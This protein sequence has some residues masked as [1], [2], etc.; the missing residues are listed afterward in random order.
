L[1]QNLSRTRLFL[2]AVAAVSVALIGF[3]AAAQASPPP[4]SLNVFCPPFPLEHEDAQLSAG[5]AGDNLETRLVSFGRR[6]IIAGELRDAEG[7]GIPGEPLCIEERPRFPLAPYTMIG[8]TTTRADGTWS[9]TVPSGPSRKLRINYGGDPTATSVFLELSV[10]AHAVLHLRRA[11]AR[12]SR[13]VFAIGRIAGPA[14]GRRVVILHARTRRGRD[15]IVEEA[16]TDVLGRFR[17]P[18]TLRR[19]GSK[20]LAVWVVVPVQGGYPYVRGRSAKRFARVG[21]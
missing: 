4:P 9:F 21:R 14:A 16:M 8:T 19:S 17:I 6:T 13:R 5:F 12:P 3:A 20:R 18:L 11:H 15:V 7:H 1:R 2:S 10:R